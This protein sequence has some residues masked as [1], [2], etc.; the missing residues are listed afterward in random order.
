M[1]VY[2]STVIPMEEEYR[3]Y[4]VNHELRAICQYKGNS[5]TCDSNVVQKAIH[6]LS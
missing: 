4:I 3:A 1:E 2:C 5:K 6:A